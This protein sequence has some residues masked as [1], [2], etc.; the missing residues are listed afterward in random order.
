MDTFI[1][2]SAKKLN[3]QVENS[4]KNPATYTETS[5]NAETVEV[6]NNIMYII[7]GVGAIFMITTM[8][9]QH[10]TL[11]VENFAERTI[12]KIFSLN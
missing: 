3:Q 5:L 2:D 8:I 12:S 11:T 6:I 4:V 10:L 7:M 1:K 9:V